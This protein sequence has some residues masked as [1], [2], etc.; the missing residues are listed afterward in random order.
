MNII[1]LIG[2]LRYS[3]A[4]NVLRCIATEIAHAGHNVE[5][6][7]RAEGYENETLPD[8]T[9]KYCGAKGNALQRRLGRN[10]KIRNE[11]NDFK[12]DVVIGFGFPMNFDAVAASIG[13]SAKSIICER[14]DPYT[15]SENKQ[16]ELQKKI[17]YKFA[18]G[19]VVQTPS[20][21]EFYREHSAGKK[22]V[23]VIPNPVRQGFS[24][25]PKRNTTEDYL[26]TVGRLDDEQKNQS[27]LIIAFSTVENKYP[28]LKL[29]IAGEGPDRE[30]YEKLIETLG[31][32]KKV[33]MLGNVSDP[34]SVVRDSTLFILTSNHEGMPNA[35]IEAMAQ[36]KPCI[37]TKCSGGGAEYLIHDGEN[38]ILID[39]DDVEAC[40]LSIDLLM[41]DESKRNSLGEKAFEV[42]RMLNLEAI[43]NRWIDYISEIC[44]K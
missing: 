32:H 36:G 20:I 3:G 2:Q 29:Y 9:I 8:V 43:T 14:M 44:R 23:A 11:I 18:D 16:F 38:G 1:F 21:Q 6:M 12:A 31:L 15:C 4:E 30:K 26:V 34:T 24:S 5:I 41:S 37:S 17:Y 35:L 25:I 33:T 39:C 42:N 40:A 27:M 13:T 10:K 22:K 28:Q 19:Y 7:V